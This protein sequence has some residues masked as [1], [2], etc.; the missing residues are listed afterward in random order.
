MFVCL[1]LMKAE[2]QCLQ[3]PP[4]IGTPSLRQ[5]HKS[6][7]E[8]NQGQKATGWSLKFRGEW[9]PESDSH[10]SQHHKGYEVWQQPRLIG[11]RV[12]AGGGGW[13]LRTWY[14]LTIYSQNPETPD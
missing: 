1:P 10:E 6:L 5:T 12:R 11:D 9:H 3:S 7:A 13:S 2:G 14:K 4:I 8:L